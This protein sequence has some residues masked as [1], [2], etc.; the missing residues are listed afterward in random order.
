[1][2][3][4]DVPHV[5][6]LGPEAGYGVGDCGIACVAMVVGYETGTAPSVD[7]LAQSVGLLAGF[8]YAHITRH[9]IPA[10][11]QHAVTLY[12]HAGM[13]LAA[14]REELDA[15]RPIIALV[16]YRSLPRRYSTSYAGN[17]YVVL[18]GYEDDVLTYHDP[19][20]PTGDERFMS[21]PAGGLAFFAAWNGAAVSGARRQCLRV[22]A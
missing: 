8:D 14:V 20:A 7:A 21:V 9:L 16:D 4:L 22:G 19:L 6:Q 18:T 17:H 10:A 1:M 15:G 5:S 3:I 12:W 11:A 2:A 13:T